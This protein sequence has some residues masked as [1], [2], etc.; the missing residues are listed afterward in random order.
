MSHK[1]NRRTVLKG[2]GAAGVTA[3]IAGCADDDNGEADAM[4]GVLQPATGDLG[5]LGSPIQDAGA[6]PGLQLEDEGVPYEIDIRREDTETEPEVGI[7]RAQALVDAGYPSITGAASSGVTIAVA[8]DIYLPEEVVGISPASTSPDITDIEGRYL[9]RTCPTDALQ[10]VAAA[11]LAYEDRGLETASTF[12][13]N[14]DYGEGL[15]D[16]FVANFEDVGGE[17]FEE[18]AFEAEQPSYDSELEV[19]LGDD[20]DLLY[21][22]GY[23][24]SGEQIF[25][26]FYENFDA[27]D[28]VVMVADGMQSNSLPGDVD[29]PMENVIGTAPAAVGPD[30]ETF[31]ELYEAEYGRDPGV[32]NAQAYDATAVHLLAQFRADELSGPAVADEVR[33]VANPG[34]E[35]V[36]PSTLADGLEMAADGEE[37]QYQGASSEI[38]FDENGD[39]DAATFDIFEFDMDG[40]TVTEQFEL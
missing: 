11:N 34:G 1:L 38:V 6:L 33:E 4:V 36:T 40:Y 25:R 3:G 37:I 16:S 14:N 28:T 15:N 21:V 8:Q 19:V 30:R 13:L 24:D 12:Y 7:E 26:D 22:V 29:N 20:P 23:P 5:D 10:G 18:S 32:F 35:V 39:L 9:L 31:D 2:L 27:D 17:V